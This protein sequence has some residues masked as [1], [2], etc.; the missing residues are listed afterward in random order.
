MWA[1]REGSVPL[2]EFLLDHSADIDVVDS[3]QLSALHLA[4]SQGH[5]DVVSLLIERNATLDLRGWLDR[6]ALHWAAKAGFCATLERLLEAG[7]DVNALDACDSSALCAAAENG[8]YA[9]V[10]SL[11]NARA[12]IDPSVSA[13]SPAAAHR[14]ESALHLASQN[15]HKAI[16]TFLLARGADKS[17]RTPEG[18]TPEQLAQSDEMR[19]LLRHYVWQWSLKHHHRRTPKRIRLVIEVLLA[20]RTLEQHSLLARLPLEMV[21]EI[22]RFLS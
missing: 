11:V 21:F 7:A 16:A 15:N 2:V 5:T 1:A 3:S 4:S 10:K 8:H 19:H 12:D 6:T 18:Q 13:C 22:F 20:I 9:V 14:P 17:L